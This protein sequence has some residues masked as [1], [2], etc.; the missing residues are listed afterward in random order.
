MEPKAIAKARSRLRVAEKALNEL[1]ESQDYQ[2]FSDTWYTFL[3]AW[4]N[5]YTALEQG[6]KVSPQSRQWFGAKKQERK[7]DE[8]LQYL[9]EARNDDEHGLNDSTELEPGEIAISAGKPGYSGNFHI[10]SMRFNGAGYPSIDATSNDGKPIL[11]EFSPARAKLVPVTARGPV[12]YQPP[13]KHMGA[14]LPDNQPLPVA[15]L[16]LDYARTLVEEA[17]ALA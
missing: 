9:F 13:T 17:A 5:I 2:T 8:L 15:A 12:T 11:I 6:S 7:G 14:D 1:A 16:A 3:V 10:R 4:K